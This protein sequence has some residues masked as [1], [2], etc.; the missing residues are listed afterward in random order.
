MKVG[1]ISVCFFSCQFYYTYETCKH[2]ALWQRKKLCI[3]ISISLLK[4]MRNILKYHFSGQGVLL[5]SI[6]DIHY[7]T[8]KGGADQSRMAVDMRGWW[9]KFFIL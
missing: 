4:L 5:N 7:S 3:S 2:C 1:S 9:S 6:T 8:A